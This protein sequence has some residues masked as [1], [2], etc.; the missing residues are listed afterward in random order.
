MDGTERWVNNSYLVIWTMGEY[1]GC[2]GEETSPTRAGG[3]SE[4]STQCQGALVTSSSKPNHLTS[5]GSLG[6]YCSIE[7]LFAWGLR[8]PYFFFH[9]SR[10]GP[11]GTLVPYPMGTLWFTEEQLF[12]AWVA[13]CGKFVIE[14]LKI[15]SKDCPPHSR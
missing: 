1:G 15:S 7:A 3:L 12:E 14:Y 5:Q 10:C 4:Q 8:L 9:S 13:I 11:S 2:L 6:L